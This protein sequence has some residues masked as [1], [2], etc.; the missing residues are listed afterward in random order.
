MGGG[1]FSKVQSFS[2]PFLWFWGRKSKTVQLYTPLM[3]FF[4]ICLF[5][6]HL[7]LLFC[8]KVFMTLTWSLPVCF[9]IW[10]FNAILLNTLITFSTVV[11]NFHDLKVL[12]IWFFT[13]NTLIQSL[14]SVQGKKES[15]VYQ[16][17]LTNEDGLSC[18]AYKAFTKTYFQQGP[19][20]ITEY[21]TTCVSP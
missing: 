2:H 12:Y 21:V 1:I 20:A 3:F 8:V 19:W 10:K 17:L 13:I 11:C 6:W 7:I 18:K 15:V 5:R 9:F 14:P 4:S 16:Y